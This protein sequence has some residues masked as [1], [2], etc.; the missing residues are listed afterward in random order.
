MKPRNQPHNTPGTK[1][2]NNKLF[3]KTSTALSTI[4]TTLAT[5][6]IT[7]TLAATLLTLPGVYGYMYPH[8]QLPDGDQRPVII[9]VQLQP[10]HK[11][12]N[13]L[14][15]DL[16]IEAYDNNQIAYYEYR[17]DKTQQT[18]QISTHKPIIS[19]AA[20]TPNTH[21]TLQIRA[22]D[23]HGWKSAWADV[24]AGITP[25]APQIIIAGDSIASG[26]T[27]QWF[28]GD[29]QCTNA[30][31]SY[32]ATITREIAKT[33]PQQWA[34][35]YHNIAWAGAAGQHMTQTGQDSCGKTH[36]AQNTQIINY[37]KQNTWTIIVIT[38]GINTTNWVDII[39]QLTTD[40]ALSIQDSGDHKA[41]VNAINNWNLET[42][43]EK[44]QQ[45]IQTSEQQLADTNAHIYW[46]SYY[47][48]TG[49][50][51]APLWTPIGTECATEMEDAMSRLHNM[52]QTSLATT[53]TWIDLT[54]TPIETQ[55]W[56]GWPHPNQQTHQTIGTIIAADIIE[57]LTQQRTGIGVVSTSINQ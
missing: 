56:A 54:Q 30:D 24:W 45:D 14:E 2:N 37:T 49:T 7:T 19:Y 27:K 6:I 12:N 50:K 9:N 33:L 21:H 22:I 4:I 25:D 23:N 26:Y 15:A 51:I 11:H 47:N 40:T 41:C 34:P 48:I 46:T 31:Y 1:Q 44:L 17:W 52:I 5:F 57:N 36:E 55:T 43:Q 29:A 42:K 16:K 3:L 53:S 39:T 8:E 10:I 13:L 20:I 32:G 18:Q 28:T 38:N 35:Q